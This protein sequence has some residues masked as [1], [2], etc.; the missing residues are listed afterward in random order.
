[1]KSIPPPGHHPQAD[2]SWRA[3]ALDP[4]D[5]LGP[6]S[7]RLL[8]V[9]GVL[10]LILILLVGFAWLRSGGDNAL[11]PIA[12]AAELTR[13][14]P[15]VR[16][17]M[18]ATYYSANS[19]LQMQ[20]TGYGAYN[21]QTGRSRATMTLQAPAPVGTVGIETIG[22]EGTV[23]MRSTLFA[24]SLPPGKDW[25]S[26]APLTGGNPATALGGNGDARSQ[27]DMLKA[28]S[29]NI[30]EVGPEVVRGVR[31][32]RYSGT[33]D[34]NRFASLLRDEGETDAAKQYEGLAKLAPPSGV[35]VWV[36]AKGLL[37]RMTMAM[38]FPTSPS[39]VSLTANMQMD[40]FDF[41]AKPSIDL[42]PESE[43]FDATSLAQAQLKAMEDQS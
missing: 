3:A 2:G 40:F 18:Q 25:M 38:Q 35:E 37:R 11:N 10:S 20:M 23:Y 12:R 34:L 7:R 43:V 16:M 27:L 13:S 17:S 22:D 19:P 32:T 42:P 36:D 39:G 30:T 28:V 41:G 5:D 4:D 29:G 24:S 21:G 9:A 14:Y 6:H 1:M 33:I 15:G 26:I 8:R 31:T